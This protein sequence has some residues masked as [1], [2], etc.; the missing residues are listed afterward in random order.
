[1]PLTALPD[2][3]IHRILEFLYPRG[4]LEPPYTPRYPMIT[5][6]NFS[7]EY[8]DLVQMAFVSRRFRSLVLESYERFSKNL[9]KGSREST[10]HG[11]LGFLLTSTGEEVEYEE[12]LN[13]STP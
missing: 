1:M 12:L 2:E 7:N 4:Y 13:P 3:V 5:R 8:W 6:L 9:P 11:G 10:E